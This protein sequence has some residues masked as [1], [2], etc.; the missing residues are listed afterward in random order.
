M[1]IPLVIRTTPPPQ[2]GTWHQWV[3]PAPPYELELTA[4]VLSATPPLL[5]LGE[6][7]LFIV[8]QA[9]AVPIGHSAMRTCQRT[10]TRELRA[11]GYTSVRLVGQRVSGANP[12]RQFD[13][14]F[15]C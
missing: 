11:L 10:F 6:V 4:L 13:I 15:P 12:M 1:T 9:G 7:M 2:V 3:Y 8:G 14:T 5:E